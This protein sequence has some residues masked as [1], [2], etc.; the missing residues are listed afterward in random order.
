MRRRDTTTL[1]LGLVFLLIAAVGLWAAFGT[2]NWT[3]LG[4]ALPVALVA[5]GILGIGLGTRK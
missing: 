1:T 4:I 5:I 3:Y 2:V